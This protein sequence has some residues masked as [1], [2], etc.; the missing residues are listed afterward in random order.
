MKPRTFRYLVAFLLIVVAS[1]L[2]TTEAVRRI[3]SPALRRDPTVDYPA[4]LDLGEHEIGDEVVTPFVIANR[5]RGELVVDQIRTNCSCTGMERELEGQYVRVESLRLRAGEQVHLVMRVSVRG[6]PVGAAMLNVVEFRTNDPSHPS[7]RI[8]AVV[9][10]VFGGI[11]CNPPS[12]VFGTVPVGTRIQQVVE[13][14]DTAVTPR[15]IERVSVTRPE[16]VLARLVPAAEQPRGTE[17]QENN[18]TLVGRVE[19]T[20]ETGSPGEVDDFVRIHI[21][22]REK[23][24]DELVVIGRVT[25][26]VEISPSL[27]VL[28]RASSGGPVYSGKCI[29]RSTQGKPLTLSVDSV[30]PGLTADILAEG[31]EGVRVVRVTWDPHRGKPP[32]DGQRQLIRLRA[33]AGEDEAVLELSVLLRK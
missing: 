27:L 25:A 14:R 18:G 29:C 30:P 7:G 17:S 19:V 5:G 32:V 23:N 21:A 15:A 6:V 28:P 20:V 1:Y 26:P 8:E 3:W 4:E 12:V 13:V 16:R 22:G 11:S 10:C 24:P 2:A 33:K 9:R 31:A